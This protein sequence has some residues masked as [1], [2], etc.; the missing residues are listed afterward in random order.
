MREV[1]VI[2]DVTP[3]YSEASGGSIDL[4]LKPQVVDEPS[5]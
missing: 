2:L 1:G 3:T 4:E 5:W